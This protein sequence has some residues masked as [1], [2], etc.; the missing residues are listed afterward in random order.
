MS[1]V[2]RINAISLLSTVDFNSMGRIT[3]TRPREQSYACQLQAAQP[4]GLFDDQLRHL[5]LDDALA[6]IA[7]LGF[8]R[9][10]LGALRGHPISNLI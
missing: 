7:E 1:T 4:A 10:N 5:A 6:Q 3:S 8:P 9:S 2:D